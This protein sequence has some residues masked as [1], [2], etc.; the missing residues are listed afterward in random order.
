MTPRRIA[1]ATATV[2][3]LVTS[4][5]CF[6]T[7]PYDDIDNE[8]L[9]YVGKGSVGPAYDVQVKDGIAYVANNDGIA[10]V[11]VSQ[12]QSGD[13]IQVGQID[14]GSASFGLDIADSRIYIAGQSGLVIAD[15]T[16]PEDPHILGRIELNSVV[17]QVR[18]SLNHAFVATR[19]EGLVILDI[20]DPQAPRV[21]GRHDDGGAGSAVEIVENIAFFADARDGLEVLDVSNPTAP[22]LVETVPEARSAWDIAVGTSEGFTDLF[23]GCHGNGTLL[24]RFDSDWNSEVLSR[25][26]DGGES[27]GVWLRDGILFVADN[28]G[29]EVLDVTDPRDPRELIDVGDLN[30]LHDLFV[31]GDRIYLAD[32]RGLFVLEYGGN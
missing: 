14:V 7:N 26:N 4:Q 13:L 18:I 24:V 23:I 5:S 8:L 2:L 17:S 27:Q 32:A 1:I 30:G 3:G 10:L 6:L 31:E 28:Y 25:F 29:C 21:V 16:H 15:I 9:H 12:P 19:E 22:L 11:D 20:G